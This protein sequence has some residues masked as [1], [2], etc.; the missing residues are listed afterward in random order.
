MTHNESDGVQ[1]FADPDSTLWVR[2]YSNSGSN[3]TPWKKISTTDDL[4][5]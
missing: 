2:A 5:K 4:K 3:W 1:L